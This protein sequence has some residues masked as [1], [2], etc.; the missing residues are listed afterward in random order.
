[1]NKQLFFICFSVFCFFSNA[2]KLVVNDTLTRTATI[3][4]TAN[5]NEIMFTPET[6]ILNQIAGAPKAFYTHY[7]EFGDGKYSTEKTPKHV[8]KNKGEYDV[9]LWAT[10]NYDTGKPPTTRPKKVAIN[11]DASEY[12][13]IATMDED[14]LLKRNREPVPD[15]DMV[16]I[17]SYKNIKDY[18]TNG[19]LYLFYNE[20]KYK[21]NNFE[22]IETRTHYNEK[23]ISTD[24]FAYTHSIEDDNTFL[25]SSNNEIIASSQ[26]LQDS[27]IKTN[28]PLTIANS[29]DFY[30]NWSLLEF[31]NMQ[32]NEERNIFFSLKTTPEMVKDTSAIISVRGIYV[33]D[34]NYDNHKLKDMEMEIV[35]SHDP[36]KMSSNGTFMNYRLVRFKTLKYKIKFQNNGEGPARTI[37]LETDIPEML[38]KS[39]IEVL[40]MYPKCDICPK[41]DV[42]YSCL[43]TT[44]TKTQAIFTFK[45]IY[46]PGSEQKNVKEYDSTKGFV[47]YSIKF[48]KDFHKKKTK[49][50]TA[51]IFDK[52][53]PI[54]TNYSTTRFLPGISVGVKTGYNSFSDLINSESYFVGATLSPYKS[55]RWY[56]QVELMNNFHNYNSDTNVTEGIVQDGAQGFRFFQRTTTNTSFENIDW[57]IPIL[58]RY[59]INNFIGLGAGIQNTVSVSTKQSENAFIEQYEGVS[60]DAPIFNSFINSTTETNSFTNLRTGLLF[61]ATAGFSRIGPSLGARYI[62]NFETNFNYW[63]FYAIWK[64]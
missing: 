48:A 30:K 59:N 17:L 52:N 11:N 29:K 18:V 26:V 50:R 56:W 43:D 35:T 37:K 8:Y 22:L 31:N 5:G 6:P 57:D 16:V 13:D 61:E 21:A 9:K 46:L 39:T 14:F 55:Y 42:L 2:Q 1:M 12:E 25:A 41:R 51:I 34:A 60:P 63:Q 24:G 58:V 4:H 36:N 10:N 27:T 15:E 62:M 7:W 49:S 28:L 19:K 40:D 23:N 64:F 53:D 32:P 3:K 20:L 38:D 54:I 44:Y 47:K 45:N 33:P